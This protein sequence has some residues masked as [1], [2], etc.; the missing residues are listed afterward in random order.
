MMGVDDGGW[1]I[2]VATGGGILTSTPWGSVASPQIV[3]ERTPADFN[4]ERS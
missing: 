1:R 4:L 3:F 2:V